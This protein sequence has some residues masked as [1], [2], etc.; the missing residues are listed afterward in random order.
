MDNKLENNEWMNEAPFLAKLP[1]TNPFTTP[2]GYFEGLQENINASVYFESLKQHSADM[3]M[4]VPEGYFEQFQETI[5]AR[6]AEEELKSQVQEDGFAVPEGYFE[7]LN[8]QILSQIS[9]IPKKEKKGK[10]IKLW[11]SN[12]IKYSTAACIVIISAVGLYMN[13]QQ[14]DMNVPRT[15]QVSKA[16][17]QEQ[18]LFDIDEQVIIDQME[19]DKSQQAANTTATDSEMEDYILNNY[20]QSDIAT[21]L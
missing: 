7:N 19:T 4:P 15:V 17:S 21:N 3:D 12:A 20:S 6:I 11:H 16:S 13:Q 9:E 5:Y 18:T 10:I 8:S 2:P 1:R 14:S